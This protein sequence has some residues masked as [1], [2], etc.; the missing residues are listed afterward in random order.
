MGPWLLEGGLNQ[1]GPPDP[2]LP[3]PGVD[4]GSTYLLAREGRKEEEAREE[5]EGR[6]ER[7]SPRAWGWLCGPKIDVQ[8]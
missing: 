4:L 8:S 6:M 5:E 1:R 7:S 3:H 2:V